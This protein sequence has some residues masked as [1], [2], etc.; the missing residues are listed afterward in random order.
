MPDLKDADEDNRV[1]LCSSCEHFVPDFAR[2]TFWRRYQFSLDEPVGEH[3]C[4]GQ[5]SLA[6][7]F[8]PTKQLSTWQVD[9]IA[10]TRFTIRFDGDGW[11]E[12]VDVR[13]LPVVPLEIAVPHVPVALALYTDRYS[14][15]HYQETPARAILI[16]HEQSRPFMTYLLKRWN[17]EGIPPRAP[18]HFTSPIHLGLAEIIRILTVHY[19]GGSVIP[20]VLDSEMD[21]SRLVEFWLKMG[22]EAGIEDFGGIQ[23]PWVGYKRDGF[24]NHIFIPPA[25]SPEIRHKLMEHTELISTGDTTLL[26]RLHLDNHCILCGYDYGDPVKFD[27]CPWCKMETFQVTFG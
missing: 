18:A 9:N 15:A 19:N 20:F 13:G 1:G 11:I 3:T 6:N 12:D 22:Y 4:M 2:C 21:F 17:W 25:V 10:K 23:V 26:E 7:V 24:Q 8:H 16:A 27:I 5:Y 14:E